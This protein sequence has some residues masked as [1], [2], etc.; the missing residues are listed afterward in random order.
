[1]MNRILFSLV[2]FPFCILAQTNNL[3]GS[4]YS[5]F[6][7][8]VSTNSNIGKNSALGR[9][10]YA[11]S[12]DFLINHLNPAALGALGEKSFLFDF[13]FLT[14]FSTVANR[15]TEERRVAGNFSNLAIASSITPKSAFGLSVVPYSDVGYSLIGID[16]NVE[17]SSD[18]F[19][20]NVFGTGSLNDLRLSYGSSLTDNLRAGAY[21]SYLFGAISERESVTALSG[22]INESTLTVSEENKYNGF[23]FGLGLQYAM[24]PNLTLGWSLNLPTTLS[25]TRDRLVDKTLDF[26]PTPVENETGLDVAAFDLPL[27]VGTGILFSPINAIH[28]NLDYTLKLWN[29]TDQRDNVGEFVDQNIYGIGIEY[30]KEDRSFNYLDRIRIRAGFNYDSGYLNI[31]G[32]VID[33]YSIT[34]GLG[35]PL[36]ARA[37]S[38]LN[39]GFSSSSRG[40]TQGILVEERLNTI[41]INL[42][43]KDIWFLKRKIN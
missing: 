18:R 14:E 8:G 12:S 13:G 43:L 36:G 41:N 4:P 7:L 20:S 28:I 23:R 25:G 35:I 42:S 40:S 15:N 1:M 27:E 21:V 29:A 31:N 11:L 2:F 34:A 10:G 30:L 5:F 24:L 19:I 17:G 38:M 22:F 32:N 3:T 26:I 9:G 39:I 16:S 33:A 37:Q 6:G